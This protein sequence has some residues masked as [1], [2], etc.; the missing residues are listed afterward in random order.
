MAWMDRINGIEIRD[1]VQF[2]VIPAKAGIKVRAI[3]WAG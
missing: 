3:A 2:V 1:A